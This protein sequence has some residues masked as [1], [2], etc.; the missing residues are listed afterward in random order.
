MNR[1]IKDDVYVDD[2]LS[3]GEVLEK[4]MQLA[5]EIEQV[6]THGGFTLKGITI[7]GQDPLE[8]LSSDGVSIS[9]AG[10]NWHPKED[11]ISFDIKEL[12]FAKKYRGKQTGYINEVPNKLTRR[13]CTS[14][15]AKIFD[16]TGLLTPIT[17]T[18]KL[19]IHDLVQRQLS[20][21]DAIPDNLRNLWISHFEM[22]SHIKRI[23]YKRAIV[24]DNAT[25]LK[26]DTLDFADA[27][28]ALI[29]SAIYV[30]FPIPEG[31][32]CQLIFSRSKLVPENTSMPRAELSAAV[33]N[34]HTGEVVK[35]AFKQDHTSHKF[36]DSQISLHWICN[37]RRPLNPRLFYFRLFDENS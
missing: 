30:R 6:L 18:L 11:S 22:V 17:A 19:D 8:S 4:V 3:G 29:C 20:W 9:V 25:T 33:L 16:M 27:S 32:S 13:I 35:R 34:T 2:C 28:P 12:N 26:I 7:S 10:L 1:V 21:D 15:A 37:E 24:P 31:F 14:K 36:T 23:T 5:D